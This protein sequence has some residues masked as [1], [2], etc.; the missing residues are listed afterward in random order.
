MN[1]T[2][3]RV[4]VVLPRGQLI[5]SLKAD[6]LT[7]LERVSLE[8]P[9]ANLQL[10]KELRRILRQDP[11]QSFELGLL[12]R[13]VAELVTDALLLNPGNYP[14]LRRRINQL[15]NLGIAPWIGQYLHTLRTLGNELAH[16]RISQPRYPEA[17]REED[18]ALC[19]FCMQRV[20][21]FLDEY[22]AAWPKR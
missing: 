10:I 5:E 22:H 8:L 11:V 12:G 6:V 18:M 21:A 7:V 4:H 16:E 13:R 19:L 14:D 1:E 17:V 3:R 20:L 15:V 9:S 2:L